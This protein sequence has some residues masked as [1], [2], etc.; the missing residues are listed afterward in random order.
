MHE[1]P[2]TRDL[3]VFLAVIDHGGFAEAGRFLNSAPSTLSR[4]VSRLETELGITL[5]RRSTRAIELT[6]EGRDLM[7]AAREIVARAEALSELAE[8][9][10]APRGPLR[11][12]APV[13][14]VLHRIAPTLCE[15]HRRY[16]EI[17]L[18]LDMNDEVIDLFG[19][20][21]DVAIRFGPLRDSGMLRRRLGQSAWTLVAAPDYL[22]RNGVP[23]HPEDLADLEQVRFAAPEHINDLRFDGMKEPVRPRSSVAATNGEAVRRLVLGG[24]GIARFSDF[25]VADDLAAGR[26]VSLFPDRLQAEPLEITALYLTRASG[27]RRLAVFLEW[28]EEV[29]AART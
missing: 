20:H 1:L 23:Q 12:D 18:T 21:A 8:Q 14:F 5:L 16:P 9:G 28:L 2:Q 15:F 6:P 22:E 29:I 17:S 10:R 27:L 13:P 26:L 7:Q 19:S 25:M 11:V 4:T 3:A 24:L